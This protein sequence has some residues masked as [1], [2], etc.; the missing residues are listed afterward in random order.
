MESRFDALLKL[1]KVGSPVARECAAN[2]IGEIIRSR[3]DEVDHL[4]R[5]LFVY[6]TDLSWETRVAGEKAVSAVLK[7]YVKSAVLPKNAQWFDAAA[8][9]S[10]FANFSNFSLNNLLNSATLL[11]SRNRTELSGSADVATT[12]QKFDSD[13]GLRPEFGIKSEEWVSDRDIASETV[14]DSEEEVE[15]KR[16][17]LE[18][19]DIIA[20]S[21]VSAWKNYPTGEFLEDVLKSIFDLKWEIRHGALMGLRSLLSIGQDLQYSDELIEFLAV[22]ILEVLARDRFGDFLDGIAVAPVRETAA[23]SLAACYE[24]FSQAEKK[25]RLL[26]ETTKFLSDV[27]PWEV[28]HSGLLSLK[29]LLPLLKNLK[30][31]ENLIET[32]VITKFKSENDDLVAA[33]VAVLL[34]IENRLALEIPDFF[35]RLGQECFAII[36]QNSSAKSESLES[37]ISFLL[38]LISHSD[39]KIPE[40]VDVLEFCCKGL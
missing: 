14:D 38:T 27:L 18:P 23:Q 15:S 37:S 30:F 22:K 36:N 21:G 8:N 31:V 34:S 24:N 7:E 19:D 32:K 33:S 26:E 10:D 12:R 1:L 11:L 3:S 29:Y 35:Q 13:F 6:L 25:N 39:F 28:Q 40:N 9:I 16:V 5:K 17:K 20:N 2:Q 4:L